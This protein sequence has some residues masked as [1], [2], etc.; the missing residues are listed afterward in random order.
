MKKIFLKL[1]D[2]PQRLLSMRPAIDSGLAVPVETNE[3]GT[4]YEVPDVDY[5]RIFRVR[6]YHLNQRKQGAL[7]C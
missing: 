5:K 7:G 2:H 1:T 4:L 3:T 6:K